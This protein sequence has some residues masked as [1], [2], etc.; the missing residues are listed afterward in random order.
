MSDREKVFEVLADAPM[1]ETEAAVSVGLS[2]S[3]TT[4]ALNQLLAAKRV[5]AVLEADG[6]IVW[7]RA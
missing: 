4:E 3:E 5:R 1:T 6:L 2:L 7:S